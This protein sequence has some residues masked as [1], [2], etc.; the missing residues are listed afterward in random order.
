MDAFWKEEMGMAPP[1]TENRETAVSQFSRSFVDATGIN[2]PYVAKAFGND[3]DTADELGLLVQDGQKRA[4]TSLLSSYEE[5][6]EPL[7]AVGNLSIVLDGRGTPLCVIRTISVEVRP[8]GLV[9]EAF[10]WVEG[11]GDRSLAYWRDAHVRFFASLGTPVDNDTM[12][13]L[14]TFELLWPPRE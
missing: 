7:P 3:A 10:A 14:D 4:T 11:E 2:G 1:V 13:V 8:F 6:G 5:D 9:D 12:V